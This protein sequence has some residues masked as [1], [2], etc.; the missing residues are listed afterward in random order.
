MRKPLSEK[1]PTLL[2]N[3]TK[4]SF[5]AFETKGPI[6]GWSQRFH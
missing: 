4:G 2:A 3:N 5:H 6:T 1:D